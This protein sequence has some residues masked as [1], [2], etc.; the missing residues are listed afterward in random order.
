MEVAIAAL[1]IL[2]TGLV[3]LGIILVTPSGTVSAAR[4]AGESPDPEEEREAAAQPGAPG[5]GPS[6]SR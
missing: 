5:R 4:G 1:G 2:V 3:V 6:A